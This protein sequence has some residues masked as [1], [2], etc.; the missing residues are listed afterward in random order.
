MGASVG[1]PIDHIF[2]TATPEDK[3]IFVENLQQKGKVLMIGDGR[4]D[5][6]AVSYTHLTLPTKRIV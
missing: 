1:I 3:L 2:A 6:A 4:N 5:A